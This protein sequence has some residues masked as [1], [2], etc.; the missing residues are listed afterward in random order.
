[1]TGAAP[2]PPT[3]PPPLGAAPRR[4]L[5]LGAVLVVAGLA[6]LPW[7]AALTSRLADLA[8]HGSGA[9]FWVKQSYRLFDVWVYVAIAIL[10]LTQTRRWPML[11]GYAA[12]AGLCAAVVH[13]LKFAV[14]RA[15]P[16]VDV[17]A[18]T[19]APLQFLDQYDAFPSGHTA[20]AMLMASLLG[21]YLPP[22]RWI[23]MPLVAIVAFARIAQGR[24]FLSDVLVGGG[25]ALIIV[26]VVVLRFGPSAFHAL[27]G[28]QKPTHPHV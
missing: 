17:G 16:Q 1:M 24:H 13:G 22:T 26:H 7:D 19:F 20:G 5:A 8:P 14:G 10:L 12:A 3:P 15:R 2:H 18:F 28:P 27:R 21:V 25:L 9:R 6:V 11:R 4:L 23:L